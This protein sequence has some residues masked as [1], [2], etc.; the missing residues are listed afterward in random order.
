MAP[1]EATTRGALAM[2]PQGQMMIHVIIQVC[3]CVKIVTFYG[4]LRRYSHARTDK[5][6]VGRLPAARGEMGARTPP[7]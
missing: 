2:I 3:L 7:P 6:I 4:G 5:V 1:T